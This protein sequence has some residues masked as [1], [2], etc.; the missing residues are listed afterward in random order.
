MS[1]SKNGKNG[2]EK[3]IDRLLSIVQALARV[4]TK[5][6]VLDEQLKSDIAELKQEITACS[7]R[8]AC[9]ETSGTKPMQVRLE[10]LSKK[11]DDA[12]NRLISLENLRVE[13]TKAIGDN[14]LAIVKLQS[15][16]DKTKWIWAAIA[17]I[18]TPAITAL[19]VLLVEYFSHLI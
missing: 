12:C 18:G 5:V 9:V 10:N 3:E 16:Y 13:I 14:A 1:D 2:S 19:I 4:D 8:L 17:G 6:S 15:Q 7:E 11:L